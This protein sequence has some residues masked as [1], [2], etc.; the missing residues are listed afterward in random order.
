MARAVRIRPALRREQALAG[1]LSGAVRFRTSGVA[2][3]VAACRWAPVR[4][5]GNRAT[6][7][8]P[9]ATQR[10]GRTWARIGHYQALRVAPTPPGRGPHRLSRRCPNAPLRA[11]CAPLRGEPNA[12]VSVWHAAPLHARPSAN[13]GASRRAPGPA[14]AVESYCI[15][16]S[17][18][19]RVGHGEAVCRS[20]QPMRVF[21]KW[22]LFGGWAWVGGP[23]AGSAAR[24][25]A[26]GRGA[27]WPGVPGALVLRLYLASKRAWCPGSLHPSLRRGRGCSR[28]E[29]GL[30]RGGCELCP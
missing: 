22:G 3:R 5:S 7:P 23:V 15:S 25:G 21:V 2:A 12:F 27:R 20:E 13:R 16:R 17:G 14:E 4:F 18:A 9:G 29:T 28:S 26:A 6:T 30:A 10:C 19:L 1:D 8:R 11:S 24:R